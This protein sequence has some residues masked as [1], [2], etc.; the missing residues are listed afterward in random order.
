MP[1]LAVQRPQRPQRLQRLQRPQR[2]WR[3]QEKQRSI[4]VRVRSAGCAWACPWREIDGRCLAFVQ[5][6]TLADAGPG[7][8]HLRDKPVRLAHP[9][10]AQ[11]SGGKKRRLQ[12]GRCAVGPTRRWPGRITPLS[13]QPATTCLSS[14]LTPEG[15]LGCQGLVKRC[16]DRVLDVTVLQGVDL[17]VRAGETLAIVGASGLGKRTL[18]HLLGALDEPSAGPVQLRGRDL[19]TMNATAQGQWRNQHPGLVYQFH[20]LLPE[21]TPLENVAMPLP[22]RR[23]PAAQGQAAARDTRAAV[24]LAGHPRRRAGGALPAGVAAGPGPAGRLQPGPASAG[25]FTEP[26]SHRAIGPP[27]HQATGRVAHPRS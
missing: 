6:R 25:R 27:G 2:V 4:R 9:P 16:T 26:P 1:G 22:I 14:P 10:A 11:G 18:L 7:L 24:G 3:S 19:A 13:P 17:A 12:P 5:C 20:H 8:L 15:V 21:L 23:Q